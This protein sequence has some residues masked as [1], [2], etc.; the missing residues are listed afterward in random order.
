MKKII[1]SVILLIPFLNINSQGIGEIAPPKPPMVF[2]PKAWGF[3]L[4]IGESGFGLGGFYR[5]NMNDP[6]SFFTDISFSEAKDDRE[7]EYIDYFGNTYTVGKENRI[8]QIP[9]NIG[10]QYRLF[11][12]E[13]TDNLRPYI[14]AGVG[15]A[16]VITTPYSEEFFKAFGDAQFRIAVGGYIGFGANFGVDTSNL[17]GLNFRYYYIQFF[18][19]G[20]SSLQNKPKSS[21]GGFFVTINF[22][23]M[24]D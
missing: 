12:N 6:L 3:D 20:V 9:L 5:F 21:I 10:A 19:H 24:Q 7:F 8:F 18:D 14:N 15:P 13:L 2:P 17:I 16:L 23:F 4:M 11:A 22:G 1:V